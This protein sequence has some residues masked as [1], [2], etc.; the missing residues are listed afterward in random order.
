MFCTLNLYAVTC[1]L[2]VNKPGG[3]R[4]IALKHINLYNPIVYQFFFNFLLFSL[5]SA[6]L[7]QKVDK[8]KRSFVFTSFY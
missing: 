6:H 3:K 5:L 8:G 4:S 2:Y 7:Y 1:Q